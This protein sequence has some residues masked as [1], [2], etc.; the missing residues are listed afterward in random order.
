M[1]R[2]NV[3]SVRAEPRGRFS[4]CFH[5]SALPG[6]DFAGGAFLFLRWLV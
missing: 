2:F 5:S 6:L 1:I 3:L 4:L